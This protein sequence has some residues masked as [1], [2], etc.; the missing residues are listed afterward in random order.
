MGQKPSVPS[1]KPV[2][3][4]PTPIVAPIPVLSNEQKLAAKRVQC[5]MQQTDLSKCNAEL[6]TMDPFGSLNTNL[7]A[8]RAKAQQ[9]ISEKQELFQR[10]SQS[11]QQT[12]ESLQVAGKTQEALEYQLT[13]LTSQKT[14]LDQETKEFER[15]IRANR[16]RFLDNNPQEGTA[17]LFGI[18]TSDDKTLFFFWITL[19][20]LVTLLVYTYNIVMGRN[21]IPAIYIGIN[22]LCVILAYLIIYNA[23]RIQYKLRATKL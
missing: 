4:Q 22:L 1:P 14:K 10:E 8:E 21:H 5:S 15:S 3:A 9:F 16:R 23:N 19:I 11:F 13:D 17:F 2:A 6:Q 7:Q 12:L 18:Q 20:L